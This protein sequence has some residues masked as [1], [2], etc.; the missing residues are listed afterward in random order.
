MGAKRF[1]L[2][3]ACAAILARVESSS[4]FVNKTAPVVAEYPDELLFSFDADADSSLVAQLNSK[5]I[6]KTTT[7]ERF[8]EPISSWFG[9]FVRKLYSKTTDSAGL[10]E[11]VFAWLVSTLHLRSWALMGRAPSDLANFLKLPKGDA[12]FES[13]ELSL[14]ERYIKLLPG[15]RETKTSRLLD[16]LLEHYGSEAELVSVLITY[17]TYNF[18]LKARRL[19]EAY[20]SKS[21][22]AKKSYE[23]V[24]DSF[25]I[26]AKLALALFKLTRSFLNSNNLNA[27]LKALLKALYAKWR[28]AGVPSLE[29]SKDE[30]FFVSTELLLLE[31]YVNSLR[32]EEKTKT[33]LL[34]LVI[35]HFG[36]EDKFEQVLLSCVFSDV[37]LKTA[38]A[39]LEALL[40][41]RQRAGNPL[42]KILK[43]ENFV[44]SRELALLDRYVSF[45]PKELTKM[46]LLDAVIGSLDSSGGEAELAPVVFKFA[47]AYNKFVPARTLLLDLLRKCIAD[48][49]RMEDVLA[50]FKIKE[51][52]GGIFDHRRMTW[53]R[54][55]KDIYE[56]ESEVKNTKTLS[57]LLR[58]EFAGE[59]GKLAIMA[60]KAANDVKADQLQAKTVLRDLFET[61]KNSPGYLERVLSQEKFAADDTAQIR[62]TC[63]S[64]LEGKWQVK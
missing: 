22:D 28:V 15:G 62:T 58:E 38:D 26:D 43:D 16:V 47:P 55:L 18:D 50:L 30:S 31:D 7:E 25:G 54:K 1:L 53:L 63:D 44:F 46:T 14:L 3:V 61:E 36:G 19:L 13:W 20:I 17:A 56:E 9:N 51:L 23:G 10:F 6:N 32:S 45:R 42:M 5:A 41:K 8:A 11:S 33:T 57:Q 27:L 64:Y 40:T 4:T 12:L 21:L 48:K 24:V 29:T 52:G 39:L 34:D 37:R 60:M 35:D 59:E 49:E 2:G